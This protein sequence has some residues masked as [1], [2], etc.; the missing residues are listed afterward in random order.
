MDQQSYIRNLKRQPRHGQSESGLLD[1]LES[2]IKGIVGTVGVD[3][4]EA[5]DLVKDSAFQQGAA[6][7]LLVTKNTQLKDFY[8]KIAKNVTTLEQQNSLLNKTFGISSENA[9]DLSSALAGLGGATEKLGTSQKFMIG[10]AANIQGIAPTI[11]AAAAATDSYYIGLGRVQQVL[12]TNLGLEAQQ[13]AA[14]SDFAMQSGE[15]AD[16]ALAQTNEIA[17]Q[18]EESTKMTG[19]FKQI[20]EGVAK[21]TADVQLQYGR[22]PGSL[23]LGVIKAKALGLEMAQLANAG[24]NL[25]NIE[26]SIGQELEYQLLSGRRLV[27][28]Q[29]KSLTNSYREATLRGDANKQADTLNDILERE[30]DTL[31]TNLFAREQMSKL[32]GMDEASLSRALQKKSILEKLPGGEALFDKT[33]DALLAAAKSAGAT[34]SDMKELVEAT[35]TRTTD[36]KIEEVLSKM[37]DTGIKAQLVDQKGIVVGTKNALMN[38]AKG[39]AGLSTGDINPELAGKAVIGK[40]VYDQA[41]N[42]IPGMKDGVI[43]PDGGLMVSGEKGSIQ[44]DKDDSIVA[45]TNLGGSSGKSD[46][47][48]LSAIQLLVAAT[49]EQT[50]HLKQLKSDPLF[51]SN[52][53]AGKYS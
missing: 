20:T 1:G 13:A 22:I 37:V 12:T 16:L 33:G 6:I 15:N 41:V 52:L 35:D 2:S 38:S 50:N 11:D 32:L 28:D 25:L 49:Q 39:T 4:K 46:N 14:F 30:G 23:Q 27:D 5:M 47:G 10:Y 17:K 34:E 43:S 36:Q 7:D 44:L 42:M 31:K 18:I 26:Q 21:A 24:K 53:N 29:G 45:G 19:A 48:L 8:V 9:A 40:A 3:L 51:T